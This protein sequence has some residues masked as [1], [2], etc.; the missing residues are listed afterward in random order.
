MINILIVDDQFLT[1]QALRALLKKEPNL[2]LADEANN[3]I[4]ALE[5]MERQAIDIAIV[6]LNMPKM[7]GFEFTQKV[8]QKFPQTKIIRR[9]LKTG[10]FG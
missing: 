4:E 3:G 10:Y 6:D 8:C 1:R 7:N 2:T 9:C 5:L